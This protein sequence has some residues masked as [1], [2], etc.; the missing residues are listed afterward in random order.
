MDKLRTLRFFASVSERGS[1]IETAKLFG[2]SPST[3]SKAIAR[4][5]AE[6]HVPLFTRTTRA[7]KLTSAGKNY[8]IT[9]KKILQDLDITEVGLREEFDEIAGTLT[10]NIPVS[11]GR[12]YIRPLI[13]DFCRAYPKINIELI[14]DDAYID[15]I[16]KGIDITF[17]SGTLMDN[18]LIARKLSPIDFLTCAPKGY[19]ADKKHKPNNKILL[20]QP[21]VNFRYKQT[22]KAMPIM[23]KNKHGIYE[24]H[25]PKTVCMVDDGDALAELCADGLGLAQ[26]PHFIARQSVLNELID[27]LLPAYC[28]P[29]YGVYALYS[30]TEKNPPKITAFVDFVQQW[31]L[32]IGEKSDTA[33]AR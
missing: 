23:L 9:V 18:R 17:R 32:S 26:M 28:P 2:T 14:Y 13:T 3:I 22:G 15:L 20:E 31:L 6:L 33:W 25:L 10:I 4:L 11:Y 27:V 12:L 24:E 1:F 30:K 29:Q 19:F 8:L 16:E 7:L 21:W 5:E